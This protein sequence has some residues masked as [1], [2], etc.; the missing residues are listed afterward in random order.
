MMAARALGQDDLASTWLDVV[1]AQRALR[2]LEREQPMRVDCIEDRSRPG[3]GPG[4]FSSI[5]DDGLV[6][7]T[8]SGVSASLQAVIA[9]PLGVGDWRGSKRA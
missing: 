7:L 9:S 3:L 4:V 6:Y 1:T 5:S 8:G 2:A